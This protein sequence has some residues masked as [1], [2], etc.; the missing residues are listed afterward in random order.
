MSQVPET[1][2]ASVVTKA[3][4]ASELGK[5]LFAVPQLTNQKPEAFHLCAITIP[6]EGDHQKLIE[7]L[8]E[9]NLHVAAAIAM[10]FFG[11]CCYESKIDLCIFPDE[12]E[13]VKM[14]FEKHTSGYEYW[15]GTGEAKRT[16]LKK[17][18]CK[19]ADRCC[20]MSAEKHTS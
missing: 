4:T 19:E 18:S 17:C 1:A 14:L 13:K 5:Q 12:E 6:E 11:M 8:G 3:D 20:L 9:I 16:F 15:I 7:E 2:Q 10:K